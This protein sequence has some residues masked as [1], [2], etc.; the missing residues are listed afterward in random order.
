MSGSA[1]S[2]AIP[3]FTSFFFFSNLLSSS[4]N[5]EIWISSGRYVCCPRKPPITL[6]TKHALSAKHANAFQPC[7]Q[8]FIQITSKPI[9]CEAI[10][11]Q[12]QRVYHV[13]CREKKPTKRNSLSRPIGFIS[14]TYILSRLYLRL[15][16]YIRIYLWEIHNCIN[17]SVSVYSVNLISTCWLK[18]SDV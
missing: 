14:R 9:R 10:R 3:F 1:A 11:L 4:V 7:I 6:P 17:K 5:A 15:L 18:V 8:I 16:P 12:R 2:V 13:I